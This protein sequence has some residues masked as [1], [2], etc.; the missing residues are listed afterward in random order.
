MPAGYVFVDGASV[1]DVGDVVLRDRQLLA[2]DGILMVAL[3]VDRQTGKFIAGPDIVSRGFVHMRSSDELIERAR[4]V[5]YDTLG[6]SNG[7][8]TAGA[9]P[10]SGA[11]GRIRD[12]L[13]RFLYEET[14]RRPMIMPVLLEA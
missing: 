4:A 2:Q 1:G 9:P 5:V 8:G 12:A 6:D 11:K 13:G 10:Y 14:R 3:T 7:D